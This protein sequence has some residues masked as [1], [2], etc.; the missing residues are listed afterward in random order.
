MRHLKKVSEEV[1]HTNPWWKYKHDTY[2]KPN[3]Q[4]GDYFYGETPGMVIVI[5][6]LRDGRLV[7]TLQYRYLED[8]QSVEF[9]GGGMK[10]DEESIVAAARELRGETGFEAEEFVHLGTFASTNGML[11][12]TSHVFLARVANQGVSIPDDTEEI[13]V[14]YRWPREFEEMIRRKEIWD[15]QTLAAW[16]LGQESVAHT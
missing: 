6:L 13:A 10:E 12:D 7:L 14:L 2:Q 11:K 3:G 16:V 15:G 9:P 1:L 4:I 5:P 8:K